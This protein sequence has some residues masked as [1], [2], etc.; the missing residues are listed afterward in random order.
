MVKVTAGMGDPGVNAGCLAPFAG[1]LRGRELVGQLPQQPRV[2]D[3]LPRSRVKHPKGV[4]GEAKGHPLALQIPAFQRHPAQ[5]APAAPAKIRSVLLTAGLGVLFA[6]GIDGARMQGE[7]LAASRAQPIEVKA[8]RPP[9]IPLQGVPL[10]I[11]TEIPN[12]VTGARL[13]VEQSRQRLDAVAI[14]QQHRGKT[15]AF[16]GPGQDPNLAE[17]LT[18]RR[19]LHPRE[20]H[21]LPG[22]SAGVSVPENG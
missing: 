14:D 3:L 2:L 15:N 7:F 9:L 1:A 17:T 11:I 13:P 18:F 8:A 16:K 6:D 12:E 5:G 4:S 22:S 19:E 21:F 10:S 20:R